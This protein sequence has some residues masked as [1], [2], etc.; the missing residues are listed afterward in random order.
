MF[1]IFSMY[2]PNVGPLLGVLELLLVLLFSLVQ[3]QM[4]Q[5][6]PLSSV[7]DGPIPSVLRLLTTLD[8]LNPPSFMFMLVLFLVLFIS[9]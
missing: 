4:N 3:L 2:V 6:P 5:T 7:H 9:S 8:E 1:Y